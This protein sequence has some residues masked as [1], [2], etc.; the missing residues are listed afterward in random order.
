[1]LQQKEQLSNANR[2]TLEQEMLLS[3]LPT[4]KTPKFQD[5]LNSFFNNKDNNFDLVQPWKFG[6]TQKLPSGGIFKK[7]KTI[8][9]D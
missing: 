3:E 7:S 8:I 6:K 9:I 5:Q 4:M 1:M 2:L